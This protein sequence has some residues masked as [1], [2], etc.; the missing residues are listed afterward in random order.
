MLLN[1]ILPCGAKRRGEGTSDIAYPFSRRGLC[2]PHPEVRPP[3]DRGEP[4]RMQ[5]PAPRLHPSRRAVGAHLR[6][7]DN[8]I[9]SRGAI[10]PE[11]MPHHHAPKKTRMIPKSG[12]RFSDKIMRHERRERSADR[13][14]IHCPRHIIRCCHLNY[15]RARQRAFFLLPPPRAGEGR[16]GARSP[17]GAPPRRLQ[18]RANAAT[19][20]RPRFA[21]AGGRGR[22]PRHQ[23]RLSQA[24]GTPVVM[25]EGTMPEPPESGLRNRPQEPHSLHFQDRI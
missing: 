12:H 19:Q 24:P 8:S 15:A 11:F 3:T 20:P 6:M 16:E 4:R 18:Q 7:R 2:S 14:T 13:R 10:A 17:F 5:A 21:R 22:Y 23:S 9:H 25:P 1:N